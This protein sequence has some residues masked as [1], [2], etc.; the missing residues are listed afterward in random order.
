MYSL[1]QQ[2][3]LPPLYQLFFD[4][5]GL[6]QQQRLLKGAQLDPT[7][8]ATALQ[9]GG[10]DGAVGSGVGAAG[11]KGWTGALF[12]PAGGLW[13][14]HCATPMGERVGGKGYNH[15]S[16]GSRSVRTAGLG[17]GR[18]CWRL[19]ATGGPRITF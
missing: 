7:R 12:G 17:L 14:C 16:L 10:L 4:D 2:G 15:W 18:R 19:A 13:G 1:Q 5:V 9:V 3:L 6:A 11:W 8:L